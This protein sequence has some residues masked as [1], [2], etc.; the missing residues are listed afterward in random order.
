MLLD[1]VVIGNCVDS[2]FYAFINDAYYI[3]TPRL[4]LLFYKKLQVPL[5]GQDT[6]YTAWSR[7]SLLLGLKGKLLAF[8]DIQSLRI[9]E[10]CIKIN[11][12]SDTYKAQFQECEI[13]DSTGVL[14]ENKTSKII[15]ETYRVIDDFELRNIGRST[16]FVKP[17]LSEDNFLAEIHFYTSERVDGANYITD[18]VSESV[19]S[20]EQIHDFDY[21]DTIAKFIVKR[22]LEDAGIHGTHAGIYKSGKIKYRKPVV[23]HVKRMISKMDNNIYEDSALVKFVKKGLKEMIDEW[24]T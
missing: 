14:H 23:K 7:L 15:P 18:C 8:D 16:K 22:Y 13:F 12:N 5:F 4:P 19:L 3:A 20:S 17:M 2:M 11:Y 1:R 9:V 10:D 6:E 24:P 21:S